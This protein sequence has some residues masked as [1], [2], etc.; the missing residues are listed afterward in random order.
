MQYWNWYELM[1]EVSETA[2]TMG[3]CCWHAC[4]FVA[5][6]YGMNRGEEKRLIDMYSEAVAA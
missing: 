4:E 5:D 6:D 1:E 3:V 2:R